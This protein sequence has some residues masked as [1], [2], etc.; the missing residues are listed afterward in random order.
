MAQH[1]TNGAGSDGG[2]RQGVVQ[3]LDAQDLKPDHPYGTGQE[4]HHQRDDDVVGGTAH[5]GHQSER[6]DDG[7][8][9]HH[10]VHDT[11]DGQV[12]EPTHVGAEYPDER[13]QDHA[14]DDA[15]GLVPG[16][17]DKFLPSRLVLTHVQVWSLGVGDDQPLPG[18]SSSHWVILRKR[19]QRA[20][21]GLGVADARVQQSVEQVNQ[22]IDDHDG[23]RD[24]DDNGLDG[25]E[26]P[27]EHGLDEQR[28]NAGDAEDALD[29]YGAAEEASNCQPD[30][31]RMGSTAFLRP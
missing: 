19:F 9:R 2:R 27:L 18:V 23:H 31:V 13:A 11:L 3:L 8:K 14:A 6:Q 26:V 21:P 25:R 30:M 1:D 28:S 4:Y 22:Q 12:D 7:R 5:G 24:D 29:D 16:E 15:H 10:G 17:A 20:A